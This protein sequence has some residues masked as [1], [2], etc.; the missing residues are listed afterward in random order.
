V[1]AS[2]P[3][4]G[5]SVRAFLSF[6]VIAGCL[7]L[8]PGGACRSAESAAA[9]TALHRAETLFNTGSAE[10]SL[11][12][13]DSL[14]RSARGSGDSRTELAAAVMEAGIFSL[15]ERP[16]DAEPRARRAAVLAAALGDSTRLCRALRWLAASLGAQERWGEADSRW[17]QL[18]AAAQA[19]GDAEHEAYA[20]LGIAYVDAQGGRTASAREGYRRA[21]ALFRELR[22][23][24]WEAWALTALGR[25]EHSVGNLRAARECHVQAAEVSHAGGV[26]EYEA[27]ARNNIGALDYLQG[28]PGRA[29]EAFREARRIQREM[30]QHEGALIA[31]LNEA[32]A[33][34][35]LGHYDEASAL[36]DSSLS[37]A[38]TR[39]YAGL[40]ASLLLESGELRR[41]Q[42]RLAESAA[43]LRRALGAGDQAPPQERME[44]ALSLAATLEA[45]DSAA[46]GI[47][48]L[49]HL[50]QSL[51]N[52]LPA[53]TRAETDCVVG[54]RLCL[55]G[56]PREA[57]D[58]LRRADRT[59][60]AAGAGR[61]R[62][63]P[64]TWMAIA[65]RQQGNWA[66]S[67]AYMDQAATVWEEE[68]AQV[69][70]P[71]W[72]ERY[73]LL[74]RDL[75]FETA[76]SRLLDPALEAAESRAEA[77][78]DAVQPF[79]SRTLRERM[80]G[81]EGRPA[82]ATAPA[83]VNVRGL[84]EILEPGDLY[85]DCV[86]G[87][88]G[89]VLLAVARSSARG[90]VLGG[91]GSHLQ[92][93]L[94]RLGRLL[95]APPRPGGGTSEGRALSIASR[96]IGLEVLGPMADLLAG[97]RRIIV[98]P[99][100]AL[101]RIPLAALGAPGATRDRTL[102]DDA[103]VV[104]APSA[105]VY[106]GLYH[107]RHRAAAPGGAG[108]RPAAD[109]GPGARLLV[110]EGAPH[111]AERLAGAR[112]EAR[113]LARSFAGE[114]IDAGRTPAGVTDLARFAVLHFAAH[115]EVD[116][117]HPWRSGIRV[118]PVAATG[119]GWLRASQIA[120]SRL[121]AR[122]AV[123]ASCRSVG[124]PVVSGEGVIGLTGAFL[125]AGVPAIV[126]TLWPVEDRATEQLMRQF[127]A[128]LSRGLTASAALRE[129]Q[130]SLRDEP[131]T[132]HPFYWAGFVL[133]GN[134]EITAH[135]ARRTG[136]DA[137]AMVAGSLVLILLLASVLA[138]VRIARA[139]RGAAGL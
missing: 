107:R 56:R 103:E 37:E 52:R 111:S 91:A 72:R 106:A 93:R 9:D 25:L 19:R 126:A 131:R 2:A 97:A 83:S 102:I 80:L 110:V 87:A 57:L 20:R 100:G 90:V 88:D 133:V 94:E 46:A 112:A 132:S 29:L 27:H 74:V 47:A 14:G 116:D 121:E 53:E 24:Y 129:A 63:G 55:V 62:I 41:V 48:E 28:D 35:D 6:L 60:A 113:W 120:T 39:G 43:L 38:R 78:F 127:Y 64:L 81:P 12:L 114:R 84:R 58:R 135:L 3:D 130:R 82:S 75:V 98:S 36:L 123:L 109:P 125:S 68:R 118:G 99:D 101:C 105:T 66:R 18:L 21:A 124:G 31:T 115:S 17:K 122:L 10:R 108:G 23:A 49:E 61:Y 30:G 86:E 4:W 134:P 59:A 128:G 137:T 85:L 33:L 7:G 138:V 32:I 136:L 45:R 67:R 50:S 69:H 13:L 92:E 96:E 95:A 54:R 40:A 73:G 89:I 65:E 8:V 76:R 22:K 70:D 139:R 15:L 16:R 1:I 26:R 104:W 11:A 119:D 42:G 71:E 79:K 34:R 117:Q 77:A 51:W 5:E 44:A